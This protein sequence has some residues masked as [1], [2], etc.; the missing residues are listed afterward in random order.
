MGILYH[1]KFQIYHEDA[2]D[3]LSVGFHSDGTPTNQQL[4]LLSR[5][6]EILEIVDVRRKKHLQIQTQLTR[7]VAVMK[8]HRQYQDKE[9]PVRVFCR[10]NDCHDFSFP[11]TYPPFP[12]L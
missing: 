3:Q 6:Q 2:W 12:S 8:Y 4:M 9:F 11:Y 7:H 1:V 5:L 10:C